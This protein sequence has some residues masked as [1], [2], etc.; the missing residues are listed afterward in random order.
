MYNPNFYDDIKY[1]GINV[2]T[3]ALLFLATDISICL[4][5]NRIASL[6]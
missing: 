5:E 6:R 4:E 1:A 2:G 3:I